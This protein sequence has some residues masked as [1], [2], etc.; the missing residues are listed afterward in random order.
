[1]ATGGLPS[2]RRRG[3]G[4]LLNFQVAPMA[5]N[6]ETLARVDSVPESPLEPA[7]SPVFSNS[8]DIAREKDADDK[9]ISVLPRRRT[10]STVVGDGS[11]PSLLR[12]VTTVVEDDA[13][14]G[15]PKLATYIGGK[16]GCA[17]Y[18][19][20]AS[21]NAR[22]LL[23]HQAKLVSLEHELNDLELDHSWCKDLQYKVDHIFHAEEGSPG[24]L[25]RKKHEEVSAAL[26]EY[27]RLLLEQQRLHELP[28][29]DDTYVNS[30]YN[31]IHNIKAGDPNWLQHPENTIYQVFDDNRQAVQ[32]DLITLNPAFRTTDAFTRLFTS[33]FLYTWHKLWSRFAKPDDD[34]D[35]YNYREGTLARYMTTVVMVIASGLPTTS[36]IALYFIQTVIW[37][38]VFIILY[39]G[40]FSACLAF[41]TEARRIEIFA[42][43]VALA[44]VQVVFVGT[45]FGNT[46]SQ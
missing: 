43:S 22:N 14:H 7:S 16:N 33:S 35:G 24:Y 3:D 20:F 1:M 25:L 29:P 36:I 15:Y 4:I 42:A 17:I 40:V 41:F 27:N 9:E 44:G 28:T 19:R 31:F 30:I 23:Y 6:K 8:T 10:S 45:A 13:L 39:G 11:P 26:N 46:P 32:R 21:L 2:S 18:K 34:L 5:Q 37:R 38:L 12:R